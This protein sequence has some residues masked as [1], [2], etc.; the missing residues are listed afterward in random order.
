MTMLGME[1]GRGFFS[2]PAPDTPFCSGLAILILAVSLSSSE[3]LKRVAASSSSSINLAAT[4]GWCHTT[5]EIIFSSSDI[6]NG[7]ITVVK[8]P[9]VCSMPS[10]RNSNFHE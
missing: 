4:R 9:L 6:S 1:Y 8:V 2:D 10:I 5:L 3:P 7:S